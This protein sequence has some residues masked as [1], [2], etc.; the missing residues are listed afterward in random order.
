MSLVRPLDRFAR[1][2]VLT[3]T[4]LLGTLAT[5]GTA[6]AP[7]ADGAA[8]PTVAAR[9]TA[10]GPTA[11]GRY[12]WGQ[13]LWDFSFE[14]GEGLPDAPDRGTEQVGRWLD[15]SSGSGRVARHNGGLLLQS[16]YGVGVSRRAADAGDRGS[17]WAT[18]A[19]T[20]ATYGRWEVRTAAWTG[21]DRGEQYHLR[22]ELVPEG[23]APGTCPGPSI[24][25]ADFTPDQDRVQLGLRTKDGRTW[26]RTVGDVVLGE[27]HQVH[28]IGAEVQR[29]HVTWFLD[30]RPVAVLRDRSAVPR[31]PLTMRVSMLGSDDREMEMTYMIMDWVRGFRADTGTQAR[32]GPRPTAGDGAAVTRC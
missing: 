29:S 25:L 19:G 18:V 5:A 13:M 12:R 6:S 3:L 28:T 15:A 17:T 14:Y 9:G 32:R 4:L 8:A 24:T 21:S 23:T 7:T 20:P 10:A 26:G 2:A 16:K 11:S 22:F 1:G 27:R 31:V 30:G